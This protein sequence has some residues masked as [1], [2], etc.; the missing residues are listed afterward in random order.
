MPS[1]AWDPGLYERF[2]SERRRPFLDTLALVEREPSMRVVDLGCGTG[3]LTRL[4]HDELG[5]SSTLGIDNSNAMLE[6]AAAFATTQVSFR[7][8]DIGAF[9]ATEELASFDLVFSNA[10]LHWAPN[11]ER[12]LEHWTSALTPRG[13]LAVQLPATGDRIWE[14]IAEEVG[15]EAPF[16]DVLGNVGPLGGRAHTPKWYA[17]T[18]AQLGYRN[19]HVRLQ[20]YGHWLPGPEGVVTWAEGALLTKYRAL[21]GADLY[22]TFLARYRE[23]LL[24]QLEDVRPFFFPFERILFW[25]RK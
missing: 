15:R 22:A 11:H 17:Q 9:P 14:S 6:R 18:L 20:V 12:V 21:L 8:G 19:Q 1:D 3:E 5:A 10:A 25:A 4:L 13:Q 2:K 23:R 7:E 16:A 24:E